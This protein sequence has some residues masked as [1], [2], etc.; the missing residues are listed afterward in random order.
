MI[1]ALARP[2]TAALG[3]CLLGLCLLGV[4]IDSLAGNAT[5]LSDS[6][7]ASMTSDDRKLQGEAALS[8]LADA[9]PTAVKEWS[10]ATSGSSG[11]AESL[12][13]LRSSDGLQC[14]ELK[15]HSQAKGVASQFVFPVCQ[16]ADGEWF[17]ASGM[18]L[19]KE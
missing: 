15:L 17:I 8:V 19:T 10:N 6:A 1:A 3:L 2:L 16:D 7:Q 13:N 18:K 11:R 9:N 12:G 5:F 4:Q 14:R